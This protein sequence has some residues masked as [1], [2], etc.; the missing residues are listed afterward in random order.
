MVKKFL[1]I[2]VASLLFLGCNTVN[3][4]YLNESNQITVW[5]NLLFW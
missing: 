5:Y 3:E 1:S 2:M 4:D